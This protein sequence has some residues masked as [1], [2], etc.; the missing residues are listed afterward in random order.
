[1]GSLAI[2]SCAWRLLDP[3]RTLLEQ[4]DIPISIILPPDRQPPVFR[5]RENADLLKAIKQS[6]LPLSKAGDWLRY[7]DNTYVHTSTN[8]WINQLKSVLQAWQDET[9]NGEVPKQQTLEFLY[10]ILAEQRRERCFGQGV[11]LSTV[12][13]VK[14][15]EFSH[16]AIID[17]GWT[18]PATEEQRRLFY[19]AMTRAKETLCL[20]QRLDQRN[21]FLAEITGDHLLTR[22]VNQP[23]QSGAT[24]KQ[25]AIV[26]MKDVDL[27]YAGSFGI[28]H[29]IHQ[30]LTR[31]NTGS[32]LSMENNNGKVVLKDNDRIVAVLSKQAAQY[33]LDKINTIESVTVL[34]MIIRYRD[35]S[36]EDY[37]SR[38]KVE[39]WE[40]PL[41]EVVFDDSFRH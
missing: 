19:V 26:G 37:Q 33:W 8:I 14:G 32:R 21:P 13:S 31:L 20:M 28:S 10:E 6:P 39:Q 9:D 24:S 12:H 22:T 5:I 17:G 38:C 16:L 1:L 41:V 34:A 40:L 18:T 7:L 3:I 23:T 29:P 4:H 35:D 27:S 25:Y 2:K 15:L 11:F 36:E 30:H